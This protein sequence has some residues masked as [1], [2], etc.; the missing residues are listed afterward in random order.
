MMRTLL[1]T[2][3]TGATGA[4]LAVPPAIEVS[5]VKPDAFTDIGPRSE[6]DSTLAELRQLVER[7]GAKRLADGDR[8]SI[9]V[10]DVDLAG[11]LELT[12]SAAR[13]VRVSREAYPPR[14]TLRYRFE[15]AGA[16]RAGEAR[17]TDLSYLQGSRRCSGVEPLCREAHMVDAWLARLAAG[18]D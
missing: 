15:R 2:L 3:L 7:T 13:E 11:H 5:F 14:M 1:V 9:E 8:L 4:A 17:I 12:R 16:Q 6:R 18:L 10:I